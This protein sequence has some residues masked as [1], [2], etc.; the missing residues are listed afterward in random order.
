[1]SI[2]SD[3]EFRSKVADIYGKMAECYERQAEILKLHGA[4]AKANEYQYRPGKS[5]NIVSKQY[6]LMRLITGWPTYNLT[7]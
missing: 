2:S 7:R 3:S 5:G 6:N 1:M 4:S